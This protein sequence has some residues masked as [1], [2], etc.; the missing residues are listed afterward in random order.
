MRFYENSFLPQLT[1]GFWTLL[2]T[3]SLRQ[4]Q[5]NRPVW[6]DLFILKTSFFFFFFSFAGCVRLELWKNFRH[7]GPAKFYYENGGCYVCAD[8]NKSAGSQEIGL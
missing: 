8:V 6:L 5:H 2:K 4:Q 3:F 7:I 1:H